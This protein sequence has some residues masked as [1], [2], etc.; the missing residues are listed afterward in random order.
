M[1]VGGGD[2]P[3]DVQGEIW[4]AVGA[5]CDMAGP[6]LQPQ[7]L[8]A[9]QTMIGFIDSRVFAQACELPWCLTAGSIPENLA[10]LKAGPQPTD[11]VASKIWQLLRM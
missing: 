2:L 8:G 11:P 9:A 7:V 5:I 4:A 3:A 10:A 6:K 1:P